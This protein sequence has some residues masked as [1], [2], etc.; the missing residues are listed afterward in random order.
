MH[1]AVYVV[2]V[3]DDRQDEWSGLYKELNWTTN[4]WW[5]LLPCPA[6]PSQQ[7]LSWLTN[8][9]FVRTDGQSS[10]I[11]AAAPYHI[12]KYVDDI[13]KL[14]SVWNRDCYCSIVLNKRIFVISLHRHFPILGNF[15]FSISS[16]VCRQETR[17]HLSLLIRDIVVQLSWSFLD[18]PFIEKSQKAKQ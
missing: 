3:K 9:L 1:A 2:V 12:C 10:Y 6:Q 7:L 13:G 8:D 18:V 11:A 16:H 4:N 14:R 15:Y 17:F 5:W